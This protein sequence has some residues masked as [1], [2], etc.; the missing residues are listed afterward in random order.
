MYLHIL[1]GAIICTVILCYKQYKK[2]NTPLDKEIL[3]KVRQ[4]LERGDLF[5]TM[6]KFSVDNQR[7]CDAHIALK[8]TTEN[9]EGPFENDLTLTAGQSGWVPFFAPGILCVTYEDKTINID[10][11]PKHKEYKVTIDQKGLISCSVYDIEKEKI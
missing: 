1:I 9:N 8:L 10:I 11:A 6:R 7:N 5:N 2:R 3:E 4:Q